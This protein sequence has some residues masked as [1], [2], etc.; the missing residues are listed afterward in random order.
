MLDSLSTPSRAA[1]VVPIYNVE[2]YLEECL[3]SIVSQSVFADLEVVLVED[4]S[5]DA[6]PEIARTYARRYSNM[7]LIEKP[8]GGLGAAR[9]TG[10]DAVTA[11]FVGFLDSDDV[12]PPRCVRE[13][14]HRTGTR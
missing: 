8:N 12:L 14:H 4:G 11:P 7:R 2:D 13:A 10:L 9:N 1:V 3:D 5:Q 6:S